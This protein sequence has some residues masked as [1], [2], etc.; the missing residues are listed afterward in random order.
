MKYSKTNLLFMVLVV[1]VSFQRCQ[2]GHKTESDRNKQIPDSATIANKVQGVIFI[3]QAARGCMFEIELGRLANEKADNPKVKHFGKLMA[4]EQGEI[5][6]SLKE[7]AATKGLKL[8][9]TLSQQNKTQVEGMKEMETKYFEKLYMK[10]VMENS[11]K[12]I[13][14]YQGTSQSPDE[15]ISDFGRKY[16][17]ML[18]RQLQIAFEVQK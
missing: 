14:L 6:T 11:R 10:M 15:E 1:V 9:A 2:P 8:P 4:K 18:E 5:L 12:Y 13:E 3:E 17:P 7:L 16:L